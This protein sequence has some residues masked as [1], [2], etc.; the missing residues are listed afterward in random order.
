MTLALDKGDDFE[1]L[2]QGVALKQ[3]FGEGKHAE[4]NVPCKPVAPSKLEIYT[5]SA[6]SKQGVFSS[7]SIL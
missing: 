3:P 5:F 6:R 2:F 4:T 7:R 1:V